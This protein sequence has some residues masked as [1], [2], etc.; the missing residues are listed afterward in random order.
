MNRSL[1]VIG[2]PVDYVYIIKEINLDRVTLDKYNVECIQDVSSSWESSENIPIDEEREME[3]IIKDKTSNV[4][5]AVKGP[6]LENLS[7]MGGQIVKDINIER[8]KKGKKVYLSSVELFKEA[9]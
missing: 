9:V 4:T 3:I 8:A 6:V 5:L 2:K 7:K 1:K